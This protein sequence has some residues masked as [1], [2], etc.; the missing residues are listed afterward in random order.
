MLRKLGTSA[1]RKLTFKE[2]MLRSSF[3][4]VLV[5]ANRSSSAVFCAPFHTASS[6]SSSSTR[7]RRVTFSEAVRRNSATLESRETLCEV[8]CGHASQDDSTCLFIQQALPDVNVNLSLAS[9][10]YR[11]RTYHISMSVASSI[12]YVATGK[13]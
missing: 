3:A 4:T 13:S 8:A 1:V 7:D 2:S 9:W 12:A 11:Q 5:S 10:Q 6:R